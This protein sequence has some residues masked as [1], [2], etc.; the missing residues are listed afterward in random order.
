MKCLT[1]SGLGV[2]SPSPKKFQEGKKMQDIY[3]KA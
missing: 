2:T 3:T 1:L